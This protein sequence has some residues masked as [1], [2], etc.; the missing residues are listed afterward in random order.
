MENRFDADACQTTKALFA[1]ERSAWRGCGERRAADDGEPRFREMVVVLGETRQILETVLGGVVMLSRRDRLNAQHA[2]AA[3]NTIL[4]DTRALLLG[5][6]LEEVTEADLAALE[7]DLMMIDYRGAAGPLRALFE[8]LERLVRRAEAL[9]RSVAAPRDA[10][11][12]S[13]A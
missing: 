6:A 11:P 5:R 3:V 12:P 8:R 1:A 7:F 9:Y 13:A 2:A 4:A 10:F